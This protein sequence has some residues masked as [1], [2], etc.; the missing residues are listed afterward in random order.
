MSKVYPHAL[1]AGSGAK[2]VPDRIAGVENVKG[3]LVTLG[4][5]EDGAS[6]QEGDQL[7]HQLR[8]PPELFLCSILHFTG[9]G[10]LE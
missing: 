1:W 6:V 3:Q 4:K 2:F 8:A 10:W 7:L 9:L 5:G